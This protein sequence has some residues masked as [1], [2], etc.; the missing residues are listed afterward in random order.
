MRIL[1]VL[2]MLMAAPALA[3]KLDVQHYGTSGHPT[4]AFA[5]DDGKYVLV[6]VDVG[7]GSSGID[8]F[9][10]EGGKL[11]KVAFQALGGE[12]AQGI[13][14]IPHTKIL[15]VGL[16]NAGV[17]FLSLDETLRGKAKAAVLTQGEGSGSGYLAVTPDGQYL[18][19]ANEY[20]DGGNIGV[21][22]LHRSEAGTVKPETLAHIPTP[23]AT[24]GVAISPDGTTVYTVGE[25]VRPDTAARLPGHGVPELER[26]SCVQGRADRARP[27]GALYVIDVAKAAALTAG[28]TPQ[29]ARHAVVAAMDAGCSPVREASTAD[30][31]TVYVTARGDNAVLAF[32]AHKLETDR[33]H[34]FLRAIP[35]GGEAPVGVRLF[36]GG[37]AMLVANSN[38]FAGGNGNAT[39]FDLSDPAK[40]VLRQTIKTGAFPRNITVSADGAT[41]YL[42]VFN[43]DELL[44]L[45]ETL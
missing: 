34:A 2:L 25:V 42:T 29:D 14:L 45:R 22:A 21:I 19:V 41:L 9:E 11:K 28:T 32:D 39:V 12:N 17:A 1:A 5:T 7:R 35:S 6:T 15:A 24:P 37:K 43:G 3:Q 26:S 44:V 8:V 27:N 33:E 30:G 4:E 23:N 36:D 40:P 10:D 20:G 16:S 38:R 31:A 13:L 18:F